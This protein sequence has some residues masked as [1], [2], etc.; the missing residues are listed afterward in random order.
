MG[1]IEIIS[2]RQANGAFRKAFEMVVNLVRPITEEFDRFCMRTLKYTFEGKRY[3]IGRTTAQALHCLG[4]LANGIDV[5]SD[6]FEDEPR[7]FP[8]YFPSQREAAGQYQEPGL[9]GKEDLV[10]EWQAQKQPSL[11]ELLAPGQE[12]A[13]ASH[14]EFTI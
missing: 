10:K 5:A 4:A 11:Q 9:I 7:R 6:A 12:S 2:D 14:D 8:A 1:R 3:W 13:A